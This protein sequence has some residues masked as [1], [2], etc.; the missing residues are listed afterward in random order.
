M[1]KVLLC[2]GQEGNVFLLLLLGVG[3]RH[4]FPLDAFRRVQRRRLRRFFLLNREFS[5]GVTVTKVLTFSGLNN[6]IFQIP[7]R[8]G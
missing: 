6:K 8:G 2:S 4:L 7:K 5:R 1:S 3:H